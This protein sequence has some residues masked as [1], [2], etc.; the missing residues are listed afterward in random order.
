MNYTILA[1]LVCLAMVHVL[2]SELLTSLEKSIVLVMGKAR[3]APTKVTTIP[4]PE[5]S[6]AVVTTRISDILKFELELEGL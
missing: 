4:R 6:A 1:T 3:V 5:L 2:T